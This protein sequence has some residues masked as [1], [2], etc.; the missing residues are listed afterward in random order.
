MQNKGKVVLAYSGGLDTSVAIKWLQEQGYDVVTFTADVGQS[1]IDLEAIER[2]AYNTGA[3][4]AYVMD[5]RKDFVESFVQPALQ[6]N[7][8]Y[9]GKYPLNSALSRPLI[10][11]Y[12]VWIAEVEGAVAVAHGCTGKGQDQVRIEVC[13]NALNPDLE[14]LAPVRDWHFSR[15][16]E[17]AFAAKHGIPVPNETSG[18]YSIDENMW[19]RSIECGVLED[20]WQE[21]PSDAF[22]ITADPWDTPEDVKYIEVGFEKGKPVS[23]DGE[24]VDGVT[25]I[26]ELNKVA[27]AYGVGR[28]D[29]L[30]DRL[31]GF[32]SREVYECPAAK[33]LI[34]AHK[35]LESITLPK[36]VL[37]GK[38]NMEAQYGQMAYEANWFSP[39]KEALDA[40]FGHIQQ[41]VTG[42]VRLRLYKGQAV[43]VGVKSG[44][45][46]YSE[47]L[48]TYT[49]ADEFDHGA[50][51]GFIK[52]WGLPVKTWKQAHPDLAEKQ[53][54]LKV[55][56]GTGR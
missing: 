46:L 52:V 24:N 49:D 39:F 35:A 9:E 30:E 48:A 47:G 11:K 29:M 51:I 43:V 19:G 16:A 45:G 3:V 33:V 10:A 7:A 54:P 12:L 41:H 42:V 50:A 53:P 28:I 2:K 56:G 36:D 32:K 15:E 44:E 37:L 13:V 40:F 27:G 4:N 26:S 20:P 38:T 8:L 23:L 21:P 6:A 17:V 18:I 1:V 22:R 34:D 5:L 55:V 14:V 25:M 31:V